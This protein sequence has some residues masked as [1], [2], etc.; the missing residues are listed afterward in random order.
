M[1]YEHFRKGQQ[2]YIKPYSSEPKQ[3]L[4]YP[5]QYVIASEDGYS[6]GWDVWDGIDMEGNEISFYG[7]SVQTVFLF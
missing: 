3:G 7:F 5:G 6:G 4:T 1:K 2:L